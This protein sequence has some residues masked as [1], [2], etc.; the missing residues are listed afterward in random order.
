MSCKRETGGLHTPGCPAPGGHDGSI[1]SEQP[2]VLS[3]KAQ[4]PC[5]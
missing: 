4:G 1:G 2:A 3:Q 5:N